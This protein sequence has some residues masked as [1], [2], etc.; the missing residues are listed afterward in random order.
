MAKILVLGIGNMLLTDDGVGVFAA[1]A[2]QGETWPDNVRILDAGTF[3]HDIF[4]LFEGYDSLLVL[5]IVHCGGTPGAIYRL[6]EDEL[7][8]NENQR[9][10]LHDIDLID[11]LN[12]AEMLHKKRP[13][14]LVLGM[15]P[16]DYTSWNIGLSRAVQERFEDFLTAARREI[17][18][19][20][21]S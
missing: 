10:S 14:L 15:E 6:S 2:L 1:Q 8:K 7:V 21:A 13:H 19:L 20:A 3:T 4:Y 9:L 16:E 12:M 18:A 17:R 11:S 5:D